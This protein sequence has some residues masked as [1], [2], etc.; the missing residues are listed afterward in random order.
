MSTMTTPKKPGRPKR[1]PPEP[2]QIKV[3][4]EMARA[5]ERLAKRRFHSRTLELVLILEKELR[6]EGLWPPPTDEDE[7]AE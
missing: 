4:P 7:E 5:L 6:A 1:E 3:A 2:I